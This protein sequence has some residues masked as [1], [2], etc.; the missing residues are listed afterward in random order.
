MDES[1][2]AKYFKS[3][4]MINCAM[5][6]SVATLNTSEQIVDSKYQ[7]SLWLIIHSMVLQTQVVNEIE[8]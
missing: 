7:T 3:N 5:S 2:P 8:R 6:G 4:K 1:F